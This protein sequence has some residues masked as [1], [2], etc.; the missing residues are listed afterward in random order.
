MKSKELRKIESEK[1]THLL[2]SVSDETLK[3]I[4]K[5]IIDKDILIIIGDTGEKFYEEQV[6]GIGR[7]TFYTGEGYEYYYSQIPSIDGYIDIQE[8]IKE[9]LNEIKS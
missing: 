5:D 7:T 1:L 3:L 2:S 4:N 8:V 6:Y 9:Y